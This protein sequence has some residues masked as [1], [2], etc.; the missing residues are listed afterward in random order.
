[1]PKKK[2]R[3]GGLH[4]EGRK[5]KVVHRECGGRGGKDVKRGSIDFRHGEVGG[6]RCGGG[7]GGSRGTETF[8]L[9]GK[10]GKK[11]KTRS[12]EQEEGESPPK[13]AFLSAG[14]KER[15]K[16]KGGSLSSLTEG[17]KKK[18]GGALKKKKRRL[19]PLKGKRL[20]RQKKGR[21]EEEPLAS[22]RERASHLGGKEG[23]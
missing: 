21:V 5:K 8:P 3:G 7:K 16:R 11:E 4:K 6:E 18:R 9:E 20:A 22:E 12:D 2:C 17:G 1:L 19:L 10:K 15:K 14:Q 23:K 13:G